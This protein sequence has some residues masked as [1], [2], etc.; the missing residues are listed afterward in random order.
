MRVG[1][2]HNPIYRVVVTDSR[3]ARGG[4]YLELVGR[5]NPRSEELWLNLPRIRYWLDHGAQ[6]TERVRSLITISQRTSATNPKVGKGGEDEGADRI[7][8]KGAC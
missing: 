4:K 7:H 3:E 8:R 1:G 2:R 5:Y 6:P